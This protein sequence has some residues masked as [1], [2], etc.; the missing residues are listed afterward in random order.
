M[1]KEAVVTQFK[2]LSQHVPGGTEKNHENLGSPHWNLNPL[3][4]E[5]DAAMVTG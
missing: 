4:P 3:S 1:W 5:N 2:A